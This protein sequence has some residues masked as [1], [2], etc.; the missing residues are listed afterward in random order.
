MIRAV[1]DGG[2]TSDAG[3]NGPAAE[4]IESSRRPGG[5]VAAP[6]V[7]PRPDA[8]PAGRAARGGVVAAVV[9]GVLLLVLWRTGPSK[10][11]NVARAEEVARSW[12]LTPVAPQ[13]GYV[14]RSALGQVLY[15]LSPVQNVNVFLALHVLALVVTAALLAAWLV[16]HCGRQRAATAVVLLLL[17]PP[18]AVLLLWI[19]MYDAFS[20]LV[21]VLLIVTLSV[22]R[23]LRLPLQLLAGFLC[24]L[25]NFEQS[26]VGVV[27]VALL[28]ELSR[29]ARLKPLLPALVLGLVLG[30]GVLELYLGAAGAPSGSRISFLLD[31]PMV[32]AN[33][34]ITF[35]LTAPLVI[36]SAL[37]GL[38]AYV[39]PEIPTSWARWTTSLRVRVVLAALGW[40]GVGI[41]GLDHS[42]VLAMSAF[43]LF[44]MFAVAVSGR[45][46]DVVGLVRLP[47]I[48]VAMLVPPVIVFDRVI[49]GV[50]IK[51][52]HWQIGPF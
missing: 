4:S 8:Q 43:P 21:W 26:L 41:L 48:W 51:W 15:A 52:D 49:L 7:G 38:W 45:Y 11:P 50:G 1:T 35:G 18:T 10:V 6:A 33:A 23:R 32:L 2:T 12:P 17:S 28:P 27:L 19:G 40:L 29:A 42:R 14:L 30:K 31:D 44:V 47:S 5:A 46:R 39:A 9:T 37:C 22:P 24:G 20:V 3:R 34:F 25:Q 36:F 16:V 13:E